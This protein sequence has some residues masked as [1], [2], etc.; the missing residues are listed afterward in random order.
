MEKKYQLFIYGYCQRGQKD[1]Y[2]LKNSRYIGME[3]LK[4]WNMMLLDEF[5]IAVKNK[6]IY[7]MNASIVVERYEVT[8]QLIHDLDLYYDVPKYYNRMIVT[9]NSGKRG[10]LYFAEEKKSLLKG[11][12]TPIPNG[13]W[14][15]YSK[16]EEKLKKR[17]HRKLLEQQTE[18]EQQKKKLTKKK[19]EEK[20]N[21]KQ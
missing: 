13:N 16:I 9:S 18:L 6:N 20:H 14:L 3:S 10:I 4:G 2:L 1:N 12:G 17:K 5:P 8:E 19:L 11:V 7:N 21:E 15:S